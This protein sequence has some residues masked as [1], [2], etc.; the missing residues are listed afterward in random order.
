MNPEYKQWLQQLKSRIRSA[1]IKAA[2]KVNTE[3]IELYWSLGKEIVQKEKEAQW[4]ERLIPQLSK[5]LLSEFPEM[6][7]FSRTNLYYVKS[8]LS[9]IIK[10]LP[11]S[12]KLR[13]KQKK[14][15]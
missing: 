14:I 9:F 12:H 13:V 5:D 1:Q 11:L 2:L 6:K 3:L 10:T 7:G 8:G 15:Q 4:G